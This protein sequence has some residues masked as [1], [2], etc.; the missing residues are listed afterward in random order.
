MAQT[1][2]VNTEQVKATGAEFLK[3]KAELDELLGRAKAQ[4]EQLRS[5]FQG[6]RATKIND[7]WTQMI[8][9][10]QTSINNLEQAGNLLNRAATDF[11]SVDSQL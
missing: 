7:E 4:M 9:T 6:M 1:I 5:E 3:K 8:P 2:L 11:S 10:L